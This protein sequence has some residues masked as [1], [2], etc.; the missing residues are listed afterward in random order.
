MEW[1]DAPLTGPLPRT[2]LV[3]LEQHSVDALAWARLGRP[4]RRLVLGPERR[5]AAS[6]ILQIRRWPLLGSFAVMQRGPIWADDLPVPERGAAYAALMSLLRHEY[7]GVMATPDPIGAVDPGSG[8]GWLTTVTPCHLAR[9]RLDRPIEDLR[10]GLHGKWRNRLVRA[11]AAGLTC[12]DGLMPPDPN[13]WLFKAEAAQRRSK[14]YAG[15]ARAYSLALLSTDAASARLFEA[16]RDGKPVAAML[17]LLHKPGATYH[18]GWSGPEGRQSNAHTLILW[19]A[20]R[21]LSEAGFTSLDLDL[22]DT[23]TA[24][25]LARFKL[26]SGAEAIPLGAT[27]LSA[28]LTGLVSGQSW[29]RGRVASP[30]A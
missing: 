11:E 7:R 28:P 27:R 18:I 21:V 26:G 16:R 8:P 9:I 22:V 12:T 13:H 10:A 15:V 1:R 20:M 19:K 3:P 2:G 23:E 6:V 24:P 14:R 29:H 25:G 30:V 5:P 17:F 4:S